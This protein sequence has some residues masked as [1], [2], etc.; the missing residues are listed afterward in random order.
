MSEPQR[1]LIVEDDPRQ[2]EYIAEEI[3]WRRYPETEVRYFDSEYS[4]ME[5]INSKS[6]GNWVPEYA[7][8]DLL[9]R[10]Y[11][12]DDLAEMGSAPDV[13]KLPNPE[14]AGVRCRAAILQAFPGTKAAIV[15]VLSTRPEH[16]FVIQ[17]GNES[18]EEEL[19]AFLTH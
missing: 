16:C 7:L 14:E 13:D 11:S 3:I 8:I 4:L 15:T 19:I 12:P 6:L 9:I 1:V 10:Y 17:K 18:L 2:A 5:T